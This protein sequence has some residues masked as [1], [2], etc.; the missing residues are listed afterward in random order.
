MNVR[1]T[2][3]RGKINRNVFLGGCRTFKASG[4][5]SMAR[6]LATDGVDEGRVFLSLF[7]RF[8]S[9]FSIYYRKVVTFFFKSNQL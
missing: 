6:I 3:V 7:A 5:A 2:I 8:L 1:S 4:V 9:K